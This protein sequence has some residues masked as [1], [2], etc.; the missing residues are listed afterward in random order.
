MKPLV[1]VIIPTFNPELYLQDCITSLSKQIL[2]RSLYEVIIVFNGCNV[3]EIEYFKKALIIPLDL[4]IRFFDCKNKGVSFARNKGLE[5]AYGEF[6][7]FMDDDDVISD[8]YLSELLSKS[9]EDTIVVA[10][11]LCFEDVIDN[12]YQDYLGK[13]FCSLIGSQ[14]RL[15]SYRKFYSTCWGK[16][17]PINLINKVRFNTDIVLG[18]DSLFM[19]QLS[20]QVK[21]MV[22]SSSEC[23][24]YR[25]VRGDSA[26]RQKRHF[27]FLLIQRILLI[28]FFIKL[29]VCNITKINIFFI[30]SRV[31]AT[32][33]NLIKG[34]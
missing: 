11:T 4:C 22:L 16:I 33:I 8:S 15:F 2:E 6:V 1:S 25:R 28:Y 17:I 21:K 20:F 27:K 34:R 3:T 5:V 29:W 19:S 10:N 23:I 13:V 14:Y 31:I 26:S 30:F 18:E 7:T 12:Y 24:Y 9:S 32:F